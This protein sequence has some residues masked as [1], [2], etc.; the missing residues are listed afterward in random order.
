MMDFA[1]KR[2][3]FVCPVFYNY[4]DLIIEK[5]KEKGAEVT[6]I[7]ERNYTILFSIVNNFFPKL[8]PRFQ[9]Y[10]YFSYFKK[11]KSKQYDYLFVIRGYMLPAQFI[12][13]IE[14]LN[15]NIIKLMYQWDSNH[16]NEYLSKIS[17]FNKVFSFDYEDSKLNSKINYLPLF[18]ADDIKALQN[19][20]INEKYDFLFF[21]VYF[22]ERYLEAKK[23]KKLAIQLNLKVDIYIYIPLKTYIKE[24]LKGVSFD[25]SIV[26]TKSLSR[27]QYLSKLIGS[28]TII[29]VSS[30]TQTGLAMRIIEAMACN[31]VIITTNTYLKNNFKDNPNI[32]LLD[33]D[34][35]NLDLKAINFDK[36]HSYDSSNLLSIDSWL[37]K[38]FTL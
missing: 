16:N 9:I 33:S 11:I 8:M 15:P 13:E 17:K 12:S 32:I 26:F 22:K 1:N 5:L 29:D 20:A 34:I 4:H 3:L 7:P 19:I 18:Y 28:E 38:I 27:V 35:E 31:K 21:G 37:T 10:H 36:N 23:I 2:I 6:F 24:K 25:E 14:K 30:P